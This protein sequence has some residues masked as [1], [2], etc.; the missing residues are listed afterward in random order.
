MPAWFDISAQGLNDCDLYR[1]TRLHGD[2]TDTVFTFKGLAAGGEQSRRDQYRDTALA[3][4]CRA[5][6][7]A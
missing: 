5:F 3:H 4:E 2:A 7:E 6:Y 1:I